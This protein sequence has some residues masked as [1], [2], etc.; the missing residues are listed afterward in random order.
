MCVHVMQADLMEK[1]GLYMDYVE[2]QD[3]LKETKAKIV[4]GKERLE[5]I[6]AEI[7]RDQAPLL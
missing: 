3:K 5:Q 4:Q 2:A 6:R 7:A 1:K